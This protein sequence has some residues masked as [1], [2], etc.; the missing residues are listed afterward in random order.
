MHSHRLAGLLFLV[1]AVDPVVGLFHAFAKKVARK[2]YTVKGVVKVHTDVAA[3]VAVV[4]PQKK[5]ALDSKALWA[6]AQKAGFQPV[7]LEGPSG[8][9]EPDPKSLSAWW[10]DTSRTSTRSTRCAIWPAAAARK[11]SWAA[12][13]SISV[14]A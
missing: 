2:L 4:T 8:K 7:R 13:R 12:V 6:A 11:W 5:K 9:F 14:L 1:L 3:D 10:A